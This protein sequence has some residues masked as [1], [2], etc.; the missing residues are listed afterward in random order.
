VAGLVFTTLSEPFLES[1]FGAEWE[2]KAPVEMVKWATQ[3][4]AESTDQQL[5]I[6]TQVLAHEL[7]MGYENLENL[8]LMY[9]GGEKIRNLQHA[10]DLC[11]ACTQGFLRLGLQHNL[12]LILK[13]E[14]ARIATDE[15]LEKHGIP[16]SMS[17]D[18]KQ[19]DRGV[20]LGVGSA[21]AAA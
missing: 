16:A 19:P 1:E 13:A 11:T 9:V 21:A 17:P 2:Q 20:P 15:V 5:V 10:L 18:L 8:R 4:H 7:T 14:A 3:E 6:M 12:Q